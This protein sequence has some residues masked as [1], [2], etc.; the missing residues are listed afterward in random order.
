MLSCFLWCLWKWYVSIRLLLNRLTSPLYFRV[1]NV[2]RKNCNFVLQLKE[3]ISSKEQSIISLTLVVFISTTNSFVLL[4]PSFG[5]LCV[6]SYF[7][8]F[9][10][11]SNGQNI[12][13]KGWRLLFDGP[14]S[15]DEAIEMFYNMP[16]H[17][18]P[19]AYMASSKNF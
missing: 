5:K 7:T 13:T 15:Y 9:L 10:S 4:Q 2:K 19:K 16:F 8:S 11:R 12:S 6:I 17:I 1:W 18:Y 3:G 14:W